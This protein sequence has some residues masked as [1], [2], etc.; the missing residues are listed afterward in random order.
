MVYGSGDVVVDYD[1]RIGDKDAPMIP[2]LGMMMVLPEGYE[3]VTWFGRGPWE[4]YVDRNTAAFVD[5]YQTTVTD[6]F[7]PY[8]SVQGTGYRS[9]V[10]WVTVTNSQGDG[11]MI[12][13]D[14]PVGFSALHF[15]PEDL[16]F[17]KRG[18]KHP[19]EMTPKPETFLNVDH[20]MMGVGG[21]NS[22]GARPHAEYSIAPKNYQFRLLFRP[23]TK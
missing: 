13:G 12:S 9:D 16:T 17:E 4:N 6:M 22:W 14:A 2:R 20:M 3:N 1:F 18:T 7:Y 19:V 10:K 15:S 21:D 11:W 23:V 5:L 8:P